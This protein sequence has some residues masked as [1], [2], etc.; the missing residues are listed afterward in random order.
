MTYNV[1]IRVKE[2]EFAEI[3]SF[4]RRTV[5]EVIQHVKEITEIYLC[6]YHTVKIEIEEVI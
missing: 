3:T 6:L 2:K 1:T 5:S 4:S